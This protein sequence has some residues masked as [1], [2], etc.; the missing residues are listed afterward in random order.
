MGARRRRGGAATRGT[1]AADGAPWRTGSVFADRHAAAG[2]RTWTKT[3]NAR[4]AIRTLVRLAAE[5]WGTRYVLL[6]GDAESVPVPLG[7]WQSSGLE[8][9]IP[10][11]LYYAA[12][13]GD[14]DTGGDGW[15]AER[16][17]DETDL[18]PCVALGRAPVSSS[19]EAAIFVEKVIAFKAGDPSGREMLLA[20]EV[21]APYPWFEGE[22]V[23]YDFAWLLEPL[24]GTLD[25]WPGVSGFGRSYQNREGTPG[26]EPLSL[27]AFLAVLVVPPA[28][29]TVRTPTRQEG[30]VADAYPN[31]FNPS[32]RIAF[33]LPE[34]TG[35]RGAT[36][37]DIFNLA[38]RR[39]VRVPDQE[40]G[41]GGHEVLWR[42][43]DAG[44]RPVGSGIY[45]ARIRTGPARSGELPS[46]TFPASA[47]PD[48]ACRGVGAAPTSRSPSPSG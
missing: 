37:V 12:H 41:P 15:L 48:S 3:G 16:C 32:T 33:I 42:G 28:D 20:A 45:L 7:Y 34:G 38:G 36:T 26:A 30:L 27:D 13:G 22:A 11:D 19:A 21:A 31:P 6:A 40:L 47:G 29:P 44:G 1:P 9:E 8:W 10:L 23:S 18:T 39:I 35:G 24:I 25:D 14:W 2:P 46:A 43:I 5:Q 4:E 17:E